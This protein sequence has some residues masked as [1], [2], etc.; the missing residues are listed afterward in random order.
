MKRRENEEKNFFS[1]SKRVGGEGEG[2]NYLYMRF[3][4]CD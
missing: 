3:G 4:R 1:K 2:F